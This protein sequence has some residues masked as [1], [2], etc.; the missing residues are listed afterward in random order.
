MH[1]ICLLPCS[2]VQVACPEEIK[3]N[4]SC[5]LF[6]QVTTAGFIS[7]GFHSAVGYLYKYK[8]SFH[9]LAGENLRRPAAS[10]AN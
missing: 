3:K 9:F 8:A 6:V 10:S 5:A 1:S 2:V 4:A 7:S